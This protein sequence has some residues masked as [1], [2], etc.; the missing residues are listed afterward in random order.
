[1]SV[2]A[3]SVKLIGDEFGERILNTVE[4]AGRWTVEIAGSDVLPILQYLHDAAGFDYLA[5]LTAIDY[6]MMPI[7]T[8]ERFGVIYVLRQI[9]SDD[10]LIVKAWIN[11]DNPEVDSATAIWRA[12]DWLEREVFDM[13]GITFRDHPNLIRILMPEDFDA[14]PLRKDFP[15]AGVGYRDD[16]RIID[17][18]DA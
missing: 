6:L 17:R 12:A 16:F 9:N 3:E 18:D 10:L 15:V 11:G 13:F 5:D 2:N 4:T 1:V 7:D 8:P 14:Y